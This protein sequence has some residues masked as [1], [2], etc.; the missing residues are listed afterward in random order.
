VVF[1]DS[2][3]RNFAGKVLRRELLRCIAEP[4]GLG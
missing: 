1:L 2:L 3:P 4:G